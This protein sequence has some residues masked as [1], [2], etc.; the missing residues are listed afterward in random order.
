V[1]TRVME[2]DGGLIELLTA[3]QRQDREEKKKAKK[4]SEAEAKARTAA[5]CVC[6]LW[7]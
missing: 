1:I 6:M 5:R 2:T 4:A 3:V 7:V